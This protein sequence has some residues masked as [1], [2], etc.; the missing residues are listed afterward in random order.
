MS[1]WKDEVPQWNLNRMVLF[2]RGGD[3]VWFLGISKHQKALQCITITYH[4]CM[5]SI[6]SS[7]L[8][9]KAKYTQTPNKRQEKEHNLALAIS[10][11]LQL[12]IKRWHQKSTSH[13]PN[14]TILLLPPIDAIISCFCFV[15]W[16]AKVKSLH[17][18][19]PWV[20]RGTSDQCGV[21]FWGGFTLGT[22]NPKEV[23]MD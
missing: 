17:T 11:F 9:T 22:P 13:Q 18:I 23:L 7:K 4:V 14:E 16:A 2:G 3:T 5:Y 20:S 10:Y 15:T 21:F 1:H 6:W 8:K 12:T 19:E